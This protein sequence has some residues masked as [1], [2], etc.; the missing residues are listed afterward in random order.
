MNDHSRLLILGGVVVVLTPFVL[1]GS[2]IGS[3]YR[4]AHPNKPYEPQ[5]ARN[6]VL[7]F[8]VVTVASVVFARLTHHSQAPTLA[9]VRADSATG[10]PFVPVPTSAVATAPRAASPGAPAATSPR[11]TTT[12][13]AVP[14]SG[15]LAAFLSALAKG[16]TAPTAP[17]VPPGTV[18]VTTT[19][20]PTTTATSAVAT[21]TTTRGVTTTTSPPTTTTAATTT[22]VP[23]TTT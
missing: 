3:D 15:L 2:G 1:I 6:I 5:H 4:A 16:T 23:A 19:K 20:P 18:A 14:G 10:V 8:A 7:G 9:P 21:T 11:S 17:T 12:T 13:S 22:T